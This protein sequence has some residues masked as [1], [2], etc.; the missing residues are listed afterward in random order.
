MRSFQLLLIACLVTAT[1]PV[2]AVQSSDPPL[3]RRCGD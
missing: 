2:N 1:L 3:S